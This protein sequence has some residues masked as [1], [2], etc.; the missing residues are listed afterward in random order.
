ME[1][2]K[3]TGKTALIVLLLIVTIASLVLATYAWAKYTSTTN[4]TATAQVAKWNVT[5]DK[6]TDYFAKNYTHI[7]AD[8]GLIAPGTAGSFSA[9]ISINDTEV[10]VDYKVTIKSI[11]VEYRENAPANYIN[12]T[13]RPTTAKIP[14]NMTFKDSDGNDITAAV[15]ALAAGT[16]A[17]IVIADSTKNTANNAMLT[18][19]SETKT[20]GSVLSWEWPYGTGDAAEDAEDTADGEIPV[21]ITVNY[22]V[23][24][25]QVEPE[26]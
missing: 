24:A 5:F 9:D 16:G 8:E 2:K 10:D 13:A 20:I 3:S 7:V 22:T 12:G 1:N 25:W 17:E 21:K 6:N 26:E 18:V 4:G 19:G 11:D 15:N 23:E 14:A